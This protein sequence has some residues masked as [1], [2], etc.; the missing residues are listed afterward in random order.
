MKS[1]LSFIS[2][3]K[4]KQ[5]LGSTQVGE[6]TIKQ[7][8]AKYA[9]A[10]KAHNAARYAQTPGQYSIL[11]KLWNKTWVDAM[12]YGLHMDIRNGK[13][14]SSTL[15]KLVYAD[16]TWTENAGPLFAELEAKSKAYAAGWANE[17]DP[18]KRMFQAKLFQ[19]VQS[20]GG[21]EI[22]TP[23]EAQIWD[24]VSNYVSSP[25]NY[26]RVK[27]AYAELIR[28]KAAY[29]QQ[30]DPGVKTVYRGIN[31]SLKDA[32]SLVNIK[33]LDQTVK[34]HTKQMIGH[35]TKYKPLYPVE[36]WSS[37]PSVALKF[38]TGEN[39]GNSGKGG[40]YVFSL[41]ALKRDLAELKRYIVH[42]QKLQSLPKDKRGEDYKYEMQYANHGIKYSIEDN[43]NSYLSSNSPVPVVF[44]ITP[45]QHCVMNPLF[46]NK[47]ASVVALSSEFE[48]TRIESN[49]IAATVWIPKEVIE[50]A[51]LV[52]E[53]QELIKQAG[54][55]T[56]QIKVAVPVKLKKGK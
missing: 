38:A 35:A 3:A 49:P 17:K 13:V 56:P 39:S 42:K 26:G 27:T 19:A 45:D 1:F 48:V 11:E 55:K 43:I 46:S 6:F 36:S 18:C 44:Q 33:K 8:N 28:C 34:I 50:G 31:I 41:S 10:E 7:W 22:D 12:V 25:G 2:E 51:K 54:I 32:V 15:K 53:I 52:A 20:S 5:L 21:R 40:F 24:Q 14:R 9:K 37:N 30:L 23:K 16:K 29:K 4:D 47:I